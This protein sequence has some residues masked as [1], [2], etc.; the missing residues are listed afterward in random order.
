MSGFTPEEIRSIANAGA[1]SIYRAIK[2]ENSPILSVTV[3][4]TMDDGRDIAAKH[5]RDTA[6]D[7]VRQ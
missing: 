5:S 7:E 1:R 2:A 4:V 3:C 6:P